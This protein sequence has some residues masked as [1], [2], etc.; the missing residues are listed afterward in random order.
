MSVAR[1]GALACLLGPPCLLALGVSFAGCES[2]I[3]N[4][5]SWTDSGHYVEAESGALSGGFGVATDSGASGGQI[6]VAPSVKSED[7]PGDARAVY[8]F[9]VRT[10]GAYK[11][12]GRIR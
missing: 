6:L 7:V 12:W 10:P 3:T 11:I 9:T 4:L 8:N 2:H 5:G 1:G